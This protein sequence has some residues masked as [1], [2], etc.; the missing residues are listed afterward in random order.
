MS[1]S[2]YEIAYSSSNGGEQRV[3]DQFKMNDAITRFCEKVTEL[4]TDPNLGAA[5]ANISMVTG[6]HR[7][8]IMAWTKTSNECPTIEGKLVE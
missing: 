7:T 6:D 5:W 1:I 2:V 8:C 3:F 4:D